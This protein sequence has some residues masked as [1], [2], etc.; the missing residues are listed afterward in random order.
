MCEVPECISNN[1]CKQGEVCELNR[2]VPNAPCS[3]DSDCSRIYSSILVSNAGQ[4]VGTSKCIN[5]DCAQTCPCLDGNQFCVSKLCF[6][7]LFCT[8]DYMCQN[9]KYQQYCYQGHCMPIVCFLDTDCGNGYFC[10]RPSPAGGRG[11]CR[12]NFKNQTIGC[13]EYNNCPYG[14]TCD[15]GTGKCRNTICPIGCYNCDTRGNCLDFCNPDFPCSET[16]KCVNNVC[17]APSCKGEECDKIRCLSDMDCPGALVCDKGLS[18]CKLPT[19]FTDLS[20][21]KGFICQNSKCVF[22]PGCRTNLECSEK[23]LCLSVGT[24]RICVNLEINPVGRSCQGNQDCAWDESCVTFSIQPL[25]QFCQHRTKRECWFNSQ[26]QSNEKCDLYTRTCVSIAWCMSDDE[27]PHGICDSQA[28]ICIDQPPACPAYYVMETKST[29]QCLLK[30]KEDALCQ[31]YVGTYYKCQNDR[32]VPPSCQEARN[33]PPGTTCTKDGF[34]LQPGKITNCSKSDECGYG[35]FCG[36][37]VGNEAMPDKS[38]TCLPVCYD[39]G[40]CLSNQRCLYG[41][42]WDRCFACRKGYTCINDVCLID[43]DNCKNYKGYQKTED[44]CHPSIYCT[45]DANCPSF[46]TCDQEQHVCIPLGKNMKNV[47]HSCSSKSDCLRLAQCQNENCDCLYGKCLTSCRLVA[48]KDRT[49]CESYRGLKACI[50]DEIGPPEHCFLDGMLV[51][52][53][54]CHFPQCF[55]YSDCQDRMCLFGECENPPWTCLD[56]SPCPPGSVCK[57]G[58]CFIERRIC[59]VDSDCQLYADSFC[60]LGFCIPKIFKVCPAGMTPGQNGFCRLKVCNDNSFCDVGEKCVK[61]STDNQGICIESLIVPPDKRKC[62]NGE[63]GMNGKCIKIQCS[64]DSHCQDAFYCR[65]GVC[66]PRKPDCSDQI[67][68]L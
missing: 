10:H 55:S 17:T 29:I 37:T 5:E 40:M 64:E 42:C 65:L 47:T 32:C 52:E 43:V 11:I 66:Y 41:A 19:C 60:N 3:D 23:E 25:L 48:C 49:I 9:G 1:N 50:P 38:P 56:S 13:T 45:E 6:N 58:Q 15:K 31:R 26:C 2:C 30:C 67:R 8:G 18:V 36:V 12:V 16:Y 44:I 34:C 68:Q 54:K 33:C 35:G 46:T 53:G 24:R 7:Y 27:C 63:Y 59:R 4:Y 51:R 62:S 14:Q 57:F 21:K 61:G 22:P 20:C 39:D 28:H